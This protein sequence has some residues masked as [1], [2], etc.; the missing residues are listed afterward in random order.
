MIRWKRVDMIFIGKDGGVVFWFGVEEWIGE[1]VYWGI[2]FVLVEIGL[3]LVGLVVMRF[4]D[5]EV[6]WFLGFFIYFVV[7][8]VGIRECVWF[9]WGVMSCVC[10]SD[11]GE[12]VGFL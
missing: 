5:V 6:G 11:V 3:V 1:G 10:G 12:Y 4:C 7:Y 9:C 2:G 8:C